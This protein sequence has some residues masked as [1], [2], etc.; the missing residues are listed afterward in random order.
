MN[1]RDLANL[2]VDSANPLLAVRLADAM[3]A[4]GLTYACTLQFVQRSRP[5]V[6]LA[7]WD[8]LLLDGE[9]DVTVTARDLLGMPSDLP[10]PKQS[11]TPVSSAVAAELRRQGVPVLTATEASHYETPPGRVGFVF[12]EYQLR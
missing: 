9:N 6:T 8:A 3:R 5:L 2:A 1:L 12:Y 7:E 11:L 10:L 4:R